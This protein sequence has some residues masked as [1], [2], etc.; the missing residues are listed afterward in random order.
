MI[1]K[2]RCHDD[3]LVAATHVCRYWR[4]SLISN[5]TLWTRL[6]FPGDTG[7]IHTYFERSKPV[8]INVYMDLWV[9]STNAVSELV[10]PHVGRVGSLTI[11]GTVIHVRM[12]LSHLF[13][14]P[15]PSLQHLEILGTTGDDLEPTDASWLPADF[16]RQHGPALRSLSF[17]S[18]LPTFESD[19]PLPNLTRFKLSLP[20]ARPFRV[21]AL[22]KVLSNLP[23]LREAS[24]DVPTTVIEDIPSGVVSLESLETLK[25]RGGS[26]VG[27]LP[28]MRLPRLRMLK[29]VSMAGALTDLLPSESHRLLSKTTRMVYSNYYTRSSRGADFRGS[30]ITIQVS[31]CERTDPP[32]WFFDTPPTSFGQIKDLTFSDFY[33]PAPSD[34]TELPIAAFESLEVL[35][36]RKFAM[37]FVEAVLRTLC[38]QDGKGIP[39]RSLREIRCDSQ[40]ALNSFTW[41]VEERER[42]GNRIQLVYFSDKMSPEE[43]HAL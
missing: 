22:F 1:F 34:A 41:F 7:R 28:W 6:Q 29:V 18:V 23:Q 37:R 40:E 25:Y 9:T 21:N 24:I 27:V 11:H 42:V 10:A 39:C 31:A 38:P 35:Q 17:I 36:F 8:P 16:L 2:H 4:S 19:L 13:C 33:N 20:Y 15:A 12:I 30:G 43:Y 26:A 32:D 3:D 14:G 5:P